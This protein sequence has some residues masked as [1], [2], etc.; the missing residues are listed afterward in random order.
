MKNALTTILLSAI[1]TIITILIIYI[2]VHKREFRILKYFKASRRLSEAGVITFFYNRKILQ[3]DAGTIGEFASY[4]K[5]EIVYVGCWL[6]SSLNDLD[7]KETLIKKASEGVTIKLCIISP[8]TENLTR[9]AFFFGETEND[10][11]IK[12]NATINAVKRIH[13]ALPPQYRQ[14]IKLYAHDQMLTASFWAIDHSIEKRAIFQIDHKVTTAARYHSYG[15]EI[16]YSKKSN[17]ANE[18]KKGYFQILNR[19]Q[20]IPL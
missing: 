4:A 18:I 12:I 6:S 1:G 3:S 9:Y 13:D 16:V 8:T 11:K 10:I 17:F 20:Q 14:N 2:W 19:S 5:K 15:M 7:L